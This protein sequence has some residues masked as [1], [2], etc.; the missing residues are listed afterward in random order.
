MKRPE[1]PAAAVGEPRTSGGSLTFF[2]REASRRIWR[3]KRTSITAILMTGIALSVLGVFLLVSENLQRALDSWE[4]RTSLT[5]YLDAEAGEAQIQTVG[6]AIAREAAFG[7]ATFVSREEAAA[8]FRKQFTRLAPMIDELEQNPFPPSYDVLLTREQID[9]PR[10]SESVRRI[11][12]LPAVD[13][14]QFDWVWIERM[15]AVVV[16]IRLVGLAAGGILALAA[17][18]TIANVIRLTIVI[19]REEIEIMRLVGASEWM[20]RGPLLTQG[21]LQGLTG[22]V[23]AVLILLAG[24]A[25]AHYATRESLTVID[26]ALLSGFLPATQIGALLLGGAIAGL[27]GGWLSVDEIREDAPVRG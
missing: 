24:Y 4:G 25:G 9:D 19:Y 20:V 1:S 2:V 13:Q 16:R 10:F 12:A 8:R 6:D 11:E 14:V 3:S 18:F 27:A 7:N 21:F 17:A 22:A 26:S 23:V 15:R 5:V